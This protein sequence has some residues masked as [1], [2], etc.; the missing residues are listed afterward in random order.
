[1]GCHQQHVTQ[2]GPSSAW[3]FTQRIYSTVY[4][5]QSYVEVHDSSEFVQPK[6]KKAK[7]V[8]K[9]KV[10]PKASKSTTS[11]SAAASKEDEEQKFEVKFSYLIFQFFSS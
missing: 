11:K 6:Q 10:E 9:K 2:C 4:T 5:N 7:A 8:E 1:M 3:V